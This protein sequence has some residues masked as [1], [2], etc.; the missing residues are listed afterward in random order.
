MIHGQLS[1]KAITE[2]LSTMVQTF[3]SFPPLGVVLVALLGVGGIAERSGFINAGLKEVLAVTPRRAAHADADPRGHREP[4]RGG[5]GVRARH[6]ARRRHLPGRRPGLPLAGIAAAFAGVSGFSANF[7][8]SSLDPL[9]AGLSRSRREH[10]RP[11]AHR[12]PFS[13]TGSSAAPPVS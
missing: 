10:P 4:L 3:T 11:E 2:F 5:R 1:G 6:P 7:I 13:A 8:P 12:E 9:A